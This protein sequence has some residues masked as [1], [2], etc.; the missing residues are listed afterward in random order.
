MFTSTEKKIGFHYNQPSHLSYDHSQHTV[1]NKQNS[2]VLR[3]VQSQVGSDSSFGG[4]I[5][6]SLFTHQNNVNF[7]YSTVRRL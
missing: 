3:T 2:V 5:S 7:K 6:I 4:H 1:F